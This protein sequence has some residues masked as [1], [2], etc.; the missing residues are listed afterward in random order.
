M[1]FKKQQEHSGSLK[2][3]NK[4]NYQLDA[5]HKYHSILELTSYFRIASKYIIV[6][7]N[8]Y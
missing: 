7:S 1:T 5:S 4:K 6:K 8:Q 2:N 3:I